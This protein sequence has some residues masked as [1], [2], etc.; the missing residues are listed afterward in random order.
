MS[1]P[2]LYMMVMAVVTAVVVVVLQVVLVLEYW[3]QSNHNMEFPSHHQ[4]H[5]VFPPK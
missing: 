4:P 2:R 3:T 1:D 5:F